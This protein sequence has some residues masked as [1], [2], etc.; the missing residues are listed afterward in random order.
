MRVRIH[1]ASCQKEKSG[2]IV[3]GSRNS[4]L[5]CICKYRRARARAY[6]IHRYEDRLIEAA[7]LAL[8]GPLKGV[9][10]YDQ[11]RHM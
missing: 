7:E 6:L 5:V 3:V 11:E 1:D 8:P 2:L 4:A 10:D 9:R